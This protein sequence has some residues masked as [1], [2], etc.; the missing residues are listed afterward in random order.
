M[1]PLTV[2]DAKQRS[3]AFCVLVL[4]FKNATLSMEIFM[5]QL[6]YCGGDLEDQKVLAP[7]NL[8]LIIACCIEFESL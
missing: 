2:E 8:S 5:Q 6:F 7:N 1:S 3:A 4:L